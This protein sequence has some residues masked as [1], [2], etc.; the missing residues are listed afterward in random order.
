MKPLFFAAF[1]ITI[2]LSAQKVL[3]SVFKYYSN[4][5]TSSYPDGIGRGADIG[6]KPE[7]TFPDRLVAQKVEKSEDQTCFAHP[8]R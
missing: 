8:A 6:D 2:D 1:P 4:G 7:K 3:D 5:S